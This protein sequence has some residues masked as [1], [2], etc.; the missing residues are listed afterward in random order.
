MTYLSSEIWLLNAFI[1]FWS[2]LYRWYLCRKSIFPWQASF[3]FIIKKPI[4]LIK[5]KYLSDFETHCVASLLKFVFH[6][7]CICTIILKLSFCI[8]DKKLLKASDASKTPIYIACVGRKIFFYI[9]TKEIIDNLLPL[10]LVGASNR[11]SKCRG[12][13]TWVYFLY[14]WIFSAFSWTL[15]SCLMFFNLLAIILVFFFLKGDFFI[16][17]CHM[18]RLASIMFHIHPSTLKFLNDKIQCC[19]CVQKF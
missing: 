17:G 5:I 4:L 11:T 14:L 1:T 6:V 12:F 7:H 13:W 10:P 8:G 15:C 19:I 9:G 16:L 2:M 3:F 18:H